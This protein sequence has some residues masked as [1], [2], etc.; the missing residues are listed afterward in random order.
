MD[1][2]DHHS[3]SKNLSSRESTPRDY[4]RASPLITDHSG[5]MSKGG[6]IQVTIQHLAGMYHSTKFVVE[7]C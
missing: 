2:E 1:K 6:E 3:K 7:L 4:N 5:I